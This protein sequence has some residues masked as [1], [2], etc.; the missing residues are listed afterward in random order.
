MSFLWNIL[1]ALQYI[2]TCW[3]II[4]L[5]LQK[6]KRTNNS[7]I[8][9]TRSCKSMGQRIIGWLLMHFISS[10]DK[11]G[12]NLNLIWV[13]G[14]GLSLRALFIFKKT[15][16]SIYVVFCMFPW[17]TLV[18]TLDYIHLYTTYSYILKYYSL[19]PFARFRPS[20]FAQVLLPQA[21]G[22]HGRAGNDIEV[23]GM[24]W[25][26]VCCSRPFSFL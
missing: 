2:E 6:V 3:T 4:D 26:F 20:G 13:C 25:H 16:E 19:F 18:Y 21:S 17:Y 9:R 8:W 7:C 14:N 23:P 22:S 1:E 24:A 15:R 12:N 10:S 5:Y 11:I